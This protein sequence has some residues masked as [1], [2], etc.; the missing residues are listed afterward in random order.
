LPIQYEEKH[1]EPQ[2]TNESSNT[3]YSISSSLSRSVDF[4][5]P[6]LPNAVQAPLPSF[7]KLSSQYGNYVV[8]RNMAFSYVTFSFISD[9]KMSFHF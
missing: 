3:P 8:E 7:S 5:A 2:T 4:D 1:P 9:L 6:D